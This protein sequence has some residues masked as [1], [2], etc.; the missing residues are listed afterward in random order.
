MEDR[1]NFDK[2]I[3]RCYGIEES[4]LESLYQTLVLAVNDRVTMKEK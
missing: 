1:I 2:T 4:V 3:L